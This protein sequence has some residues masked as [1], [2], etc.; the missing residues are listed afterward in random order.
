MNKFINKDIN[1]KSINIPK[2]LLLVVFVLIA[3]SF[4][5][6]SEA[7]KQV[8][9]IRTISGP[10]VNPLM[11]WAPW[12]T[13]EESNQPHTLVYADLTWRD[14]EPQEGYYNFDSFE[15]K[16]QFARWRKEGKRVVFRFI[17][18]VPGGQL[19]M[20]IPDWLFDKINGSG[21]YYD[22]EYGKGFSPDYSNPTF[23][24][25]HRKT[26]K[27]LGERYGKDGFFAFIEL[28]SL[29]HWGE[30]HTHPG[31]TPLP[32]EDIRNLYV[33]HYTEAFPGT[34]LL[35]RRPF[36]IAQKLN[37]GLYNDMTADLTMTNIWLD[38][39]NHGGEYLPQERHSLSPMPSGWQKAPIGGE[40]TPD[41]SNEQIYGTNLEQ[42]LL[43]LKKSHTTFIGPGS[44][45]KVEDGSSLQDGI[46]QV[47]KTIGYRIYLDHVQMPRWVHY[48]K[49]INIRFAFSNGGLAPMYYDW[50]TKL[51]LLDE[52]GNTVTTYELQMDIRNILPEKI[53]EVTQK[54]PIGNLKDG[55]YSIGIAI[56]DPLTG[57]PGVRFANENA[58]QDLI[59]YIGSFEVKRLFNPNNSL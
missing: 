34:H 24:D 49:D 31:I 29:G 2:Y 11:G 18:D 47:I 20:D 13:I 45:Y 56:I 51:Y 35:M 55:I 30:W 10:I 57:Q 5:F 28:G 12:A 33:W 19:H 37:L 50:P 25:C 46:D 22:N 53:Y 38:W 8:I 32:S 17:A 16:Q 41:L 26:I 7:N 54:M 4:Y 39:I 59:Q 1:K 9:T 15:K 14:L 44:P 48:G 43:L 21:D 23:I 42:T 3:L 36:A 6:Y 52:K 58:R 40:Q 27:A